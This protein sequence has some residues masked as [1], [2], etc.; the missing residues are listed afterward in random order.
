MQSI[1]QVALPVAD[2]LVT[3]DLLAGAAMLRPC[4]AATCWPIRSSGRASR[5]RSSWLAADS[6][7]AATRSNGVSPVRRR[8][9]CC[10]STPET[11][12]FGR[13]ALATV[14]Y[15]TGDALRAYAIAA[16]EHLPSVATLTD[17]VEVSLD[18]APMDPLLRAVWCEYI[19]PDERIDLPERVALPLRMRRRDVN[20]AFKGV[21]EGFKQVS[22]VDLS[23]AYARTLFGFVTGLWRDGGYETEA[24]STILSAVGLPMAWNHYPGGFV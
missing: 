10:A 19:L 16:R 7:S 15:A 1:E 17:L 21:A 12:L 14:F 18:L 6:S 23:E 8:R 5:G 11:T 20:S 4:Y 22:G 3:A 2:L 13:A 24:W 9:G